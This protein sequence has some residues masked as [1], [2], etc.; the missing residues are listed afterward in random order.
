MSDETTAELEAPKT[1]RKAPAKKAAVKKVAKAKAEPVVEIAVEAAAPAPAKKAS[2][3]K[4]KAAPAAEPA[5]APEA[6]PAAAPVVEAA[7]EE[8]PAAVKPKAKVARKTAKKKVDAAEAPELNL[9]GKESP[10]TPAEAPAASVQ[11]APPAPFAAAPAPVAASAPSSGA[12]AGNTA[13]A[14]DSEGDDDA[15][16]NGSGTEPNG[17]PRYTVIGDNGQ[18]RPMTAKERRKAKFERWKQRRAERDAQRRAGVP[19][20]PNPN[21]NRDGGGGNRDRDRDNGGHR[22]GGNNRDRDG[23]GHRERERD[24]GAPQHHAQGGRNYEP[25]PEKPLGPPEPA[26]GILEM[27]PKG[28]GFLRR[29]ELSF[30]QNPMDAF[31][32]PE[33]VRKYGLREGM[34]IVGVQCKG[35]RGPQITEVTEVN[36]RNPLAMRDLPLFE[37]LKAINPNKRY[38]LETT[39]ER[40]TTR[41]ID[42]M[43][44]VGR[45]QRGL[46]VAAPRA[47]KTTILQHI[48]EAMV[49]NHPGVHLMILL[50]D[51]RPEEVTEFKRILPQAE[52][53]ASNNDQDVKNHTRIATFAIERAKRLVECGEHVF[54]LMDSLTRMAR[55]FNNTAKSGA[56]MS[57]GVGVGALEIPRRL[58]AAARN[59]RTAGSLTIL[60][61]ALVETGTRMDDL[62]FQE[63]KGTGNMELVLDRKIAEQFTYP[64]VNIFKSGTRREELLLQTF[65]LDKIHM[66]RRGLAGHK[67]VEA[68]QRVISLLE[69]YPSNAQMLVDL[70]SK[71]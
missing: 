27:S 64:A 26:N 38:Q 42:M 2:R 43:T 28:Y 33:F 31:I 56:V 32:A 65:Q 55:A 58:F 17:L 62:I 52:I 41:V 7:A 60:G 30:A 9:G 3:A 61:T 23:G 21:V 29:R 70:P 46:I 37:E 18:P 53:Y 11:E 8:A 19:Y 13:D 44:P 71:T 12:P 51:E 25:E 6:A 59:T 4:A 45:G 16:G 15:E 22:D 57:G 36:G 40:L 54:M 66:L 5:E 24:N 67:P 49:T 63:F 10:A 69:R 68:I 14:E 20:T 34:Q 48:A 35:A 1:K 47:G 50:V 39:K